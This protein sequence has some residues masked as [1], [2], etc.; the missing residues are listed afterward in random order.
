MAFRDWLRSF[1]RSERALTAEQYINP[2]PAVRSGSVYVTPE[3]ALR[4]SAV[5]ACLRLRADLMS[6]FPIDVYRKVDG[7][8][9]EVTKPPVLVNPG[10]DRVGIREWMYSTQFDLDRAGNCF[11]VISK[12]DALGRP[13]QIDLALLSEVT[14]VV[15]DG[16]LTEYRIGPKTYDPRDIWHERQ[17]TMAGLHVGLS[18]TAHA[19]WTIG[20]YQS[21]QEFALNWF[22]RGTIPAA[23]LKNTAKTLTQDQALR[24]KDHFR[25]TV[26]SGDVFVTGSDWEYQ[27]IQAESASKEW[28]EAQNASVPD[29][30]RFYGAPAD[31]IDGAVSSSSITYA[32]MT[33]RNL[34]FLIMNM[35]P[36]IGRREDAL[37][38]LTS[39]PRYVKLNPDALLRMDPETR[40][41][42]IGMQID[43][44]TLTNTEARA[45]EDRAPLTP[46]DLADFQAIYGGAAPVSQ[47]T[48][49][50]A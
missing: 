9:V 13:A 30:A 7:R 24:V 19:A 48:E 14:V 31:L 34:Q 41:R 50:P 45:L 5:W 43:S 20:Q 3:T 2:R 6:S 8:A 18:P 4:T 29:I 35:G 15:R 38:S 16:E 46:G 37:N 39:R 10:G 25:A 49:V 33:Q 27:M 42:T 12:R 47:T 1:R 23:M 36:A 44:R 22:G 28:V 17:F 11:G 21:V 26:E 40:A 32:S